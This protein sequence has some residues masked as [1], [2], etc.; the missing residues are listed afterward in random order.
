MRSEI[1]TAKTK[2]RRRRRKHFLNYRTVKEKRREMRRAKR[3]KRRKKQQQLNCPAM[4][5][6]QSETETR[7][8]LGAG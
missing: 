6:G 3:R 2:G 1:L 5:K 7:A 4:M 8:C